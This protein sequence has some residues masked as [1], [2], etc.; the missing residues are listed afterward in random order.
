[1]EVSGPLDD[2]RVRSLGL[3]GMA[4]GPKNLVLD[5][6]KGGS[7]LIQDGVTLP[8]RVFDLFKPDPAASKW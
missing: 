4:G 8:L 7:K 6:A 1:M 3:K 2:I 5:A